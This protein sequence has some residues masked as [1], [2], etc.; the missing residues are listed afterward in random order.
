M[1]IKLKEKDLIEKIKNLP[2][3]YLK[4]LIEFIEYL[5]SKAEKRET[6]FLSEKALSK[7]WLLPEEEEAWKNL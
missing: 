4:E 6:L 2:S 3:S 5:E 1:Q 7:E